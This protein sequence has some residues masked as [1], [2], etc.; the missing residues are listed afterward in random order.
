MKHQPGL[1]FSLICDQGFAVGLFTHAHGKMGELI[2]IADP[3]FPEEP[4]IDDVKSIDVWR[5]CIFFPLSAA[6]RKKAVS[7]IGS[8]EI[9][10]DLAKFPTLRNGS[11]QQG[12]FV[13]EGGDLT[14]PTTKPPDPRMPIAAIVN[15]TRLKEMLVTGWEPSCMW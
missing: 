10:P 8:V 9:P 4:T 15:D 13:F 11:K 5:W 6:L 7:P 3:F 14:H 12:W 2:W 1:A